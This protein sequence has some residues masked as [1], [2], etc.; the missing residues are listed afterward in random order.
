MASSRVVAVH[1]RVEAICPGAEGRCTFRP[2]QKV[3]WSNAFSA[4][5]RARL[6][7]PAMCRA[8]EE[9]L[10][11]AVSVSLFGCETCSVC[12]AIRRTLVVS[13]GPARRFAAAQASVRVTL[14]HAGMTWSGVCRPAHAGVGKQGWSR[15]ARHERLPAPP[16]SPSRAGGAGGQSSRRSPQHFACST[17]RRPRC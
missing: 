4:R 6:N 8:G 5:R 1:G 3:S 13:R 7:Q 17:C 12:S 10:S 11:S 16:R 14:R 15:S 9:R 2:V